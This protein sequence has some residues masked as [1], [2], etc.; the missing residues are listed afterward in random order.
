MRLKFELRRKFS[1]KYF[2]ER[3][4]FVV[5]VDRCEGKVWIVKLLFG[6]KGELLGL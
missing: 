1:I 2:D 6:V 5:Y 4:E 3:D